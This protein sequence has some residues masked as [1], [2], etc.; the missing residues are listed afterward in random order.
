MEIIFIDFNRCFIDLYSD[1]C[2]NMQNDLSSQ[3]I[4]AI[5]KTE[6]FIANKYNLHFEDLH[7]STE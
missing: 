4:I 3:Q 5:P 7:L 1:L 2:H 6:E